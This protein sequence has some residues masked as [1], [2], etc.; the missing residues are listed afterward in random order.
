[1]ANDATSDCYTTAAEEIGL[2]ATDSVALRTRLMGQASQFM[3]EWGCHQGESRDVQLE[4]L[5]HA[6]WK[7]GREGF[8]A[9]HCDG[10]VAARPMGHALWSLPD[11][12]SP[13]R[14]IPLTTSDPTNP[15]L[16]TGLLNFG[17]DLPDVVRALDARSAAL[18]N[19]TAHLD[20]F[21]SDVL[22]LWRGGRW[23]EAVSTALLGEWVSPLQNGGVLGPAA[24]NRL[25]AEAR[26][27]HRH[28]TPVWRRRVNRSRVLLLD[29]PLGEEMTL[30]D[31]I[32]GT[33][34]GSG[35]GVGDEPDNVRAAALLRSLRPY[36]RT[37][38]LAWAHPAVTTW[39]DA[40]W[41]AGVRDAKIVAERVRRKVRHLL[42]EQR[43]RR[44]L[45]GG[46]WLA[47]SEGDRA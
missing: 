23:R 20:S 28:L 27:I 4:Y 43:R 36:E 1:M 17:V 8:F 25:K 35:Y 11:E 10:T 7:T 47:H 38:V 16:S 12:N 29:M 3:R 2:Q 42:A 32:T 46:Q 45:S 44:D 5:V 18:V 24:L 37:V 14:Q 34:S 26:E 6:D 21:A 41:H 15:L 9:V 22:G 39:E 13:V 40:A 19:D 33:A 30:Y 31:L